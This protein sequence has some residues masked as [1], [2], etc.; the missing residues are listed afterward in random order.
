VR[1]GDVVEPRAEERDERESSHV[2][3]Y[4]E[5]VRRRTSTSSEYYFTKS[6]KALRTITVG[7]SE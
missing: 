5:N 1:T 4:R 3:G 6:S 2:V 7:I